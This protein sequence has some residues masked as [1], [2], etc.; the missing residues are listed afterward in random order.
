MGFSG[1]F[2]FTGSGFFSGSGF[3]SDANKVAIVDNDGVDDDAVMKITGAPNT[4]RPLEKIRRFRNERNPNV[5]VTVDLLTTGIDVPNRIDSADPL[6][7]VNDHEG[8]P[9]GVIGLDAVP[10]V[11]TWTSRLHAVAASVGEA[12]Q[13]VASSK[14]VPVYCRGGA[15]RATGAPRRADALN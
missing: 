12:T 5:V 2:S 9:V 14:D 8:V 6:V 11:F 13:L 1:G 10:A 4:D 3:G 15:Q 7:V